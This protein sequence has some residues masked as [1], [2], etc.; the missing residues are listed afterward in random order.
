MGFYPLVRDFLLVLIRVPCELLNVI[1]L[2]NAE[3]VWVSW[4]WL[5]NMSHK[6]NHVKLVFV[7]FLHSIYFTVCFISLFCLFYCLIACFSRQSLSHVCIVEIKCASVY[8]IIES[9]LS[10][11]ERKLVQ[12]SKSS[13]TFKSCDSLYIWKVALISNS[14]YRQTGITKHLHNN[15]LTSLGTRI[16][17]CNLTSI[18]VLQRFATFNHQVLQT[19]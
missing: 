17:E 4:V 10:T 9:K 5:I 8:Q 18:L 14:W 1:G 19:I 2:G 3:N 11:S 6:P 12:A 15:K 16:Q 7:L 13:A